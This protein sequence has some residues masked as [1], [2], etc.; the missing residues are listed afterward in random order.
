MKAW[1]SDKF[2]YNTAQ[3]A[4]SLCISKVC[5][6]LGNSMIGGLLTLKTPYFW[7]LYKWLQRPKSRETVF[8]KKTKNKTKQNKEKGKIPVLSCKH[9]TMKINEATAGL[10][11]PE[12]YIFNLK[13]IILFFVS[14]YSFGINTML[15]RIESSDA[16]T[17][18]I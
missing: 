6:F 9:E 16:C 5:K 7:Q 1:T 13:N 14:L 2:T 8:S 11:I 3:L 10:Y 4:V 15:C 17:R 12:I 18:Q